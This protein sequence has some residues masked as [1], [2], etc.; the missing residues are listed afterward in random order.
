MGGC[1]SLPSVAPPASSTSNSKTSTMRPVV[2]QQHNSG[3]GSGAGDQSPSQGGGGVGVAAAPLSL[4]SQRERSLPYANYDSGDHHSSSTDIAINSNSNS[5]NHYDA[6]DNT[7]N[8]GNGTAST[9]SPPAVGIT[10]SNNNSKNTTA[11]NSFD[12]LATATSPGTV[13]TQSM[14]FGG[15]DY[16]NDNNIKAAN[17]NGIIIIKDVNNQ[18]SD[19]FPQYQHVSHVAVGVA[20]SANNNNLRSRLQQRRD[21]SINSSLAIIAN[22]GHTNGAVPSAITDAELAL[23]QQAAMLAA[24]EVIYSITWSCHC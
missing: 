14:I 24:N 21:A 22:H 13:S 9:A 16:M 11:M 1:T 6:I 23:H 4:S 2:K 3:N 18:S 15:K 20:G 19:A 12:S 17:D 10:S 5:A 7:N 8:N